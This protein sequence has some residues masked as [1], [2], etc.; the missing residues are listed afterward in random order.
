M[1]ERRE[2]GRLRTRVRAQTYTETHTVT[3]A[4]GEGER[5]R[6]KREIGRYKNDKEYKRYREKKKNY[7]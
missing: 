5:E 3:R 1:T 6:G 2:G 7:R 4:Q